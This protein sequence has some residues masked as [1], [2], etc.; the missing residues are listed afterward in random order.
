M[1]IQSGS[2]RGRKLVVPVGTITRPTTDRAREAVFNSLFSA[3]GVEDATVLD[4]FAG[5]GAMGLEALSR[6]A[7]HATFVETNR[8]A[9]DVIQENIATLGF[10]DRATI[11][12][13]DAVRYI[14]SASAFDVVICDPPYDFDGWDE[15][16][17]CI[18]SE[19]LVVESDRPVELGP[20]WESFKQGQYAATVVE[21]ARLVQPSIAP[22]SQK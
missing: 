14:A 9:L 6:G 7:A 16:L 18:S 4:L 8:Q 13:F 5:S 1:R 19:L 21:I 11:V 3:G 15:L 20:R 2:A 12:T 10:A 22:E 17:S